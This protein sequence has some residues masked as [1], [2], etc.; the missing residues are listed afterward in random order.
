MKNFLKVIVAVILGLLFSGGI[1][2][3]DLKFKRNIRKL[4]KEKW[5]KELC[6]DGRYF[7]SIYQNEELKDYLT[8]ERIVEKILH[9]KEEKESFISFISMKY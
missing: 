7:E 6:A 2:L 9:N 3:D 1:D 8:G 4:K 5:F